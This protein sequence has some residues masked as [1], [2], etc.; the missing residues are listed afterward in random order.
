M[1]KFD[2]NIEN[3][4]KLAAVLES[5]LYRTSTNIDKYSDLSTLDSRLHEL[6]TKLVKRRLRVALRKN[7]A[8]T[9][10][11]RSIGSIKAMHI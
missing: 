6:L 7:K 4:T 1:S 3:N 2:K 5:I 8:T 9:D 10:L 11:D